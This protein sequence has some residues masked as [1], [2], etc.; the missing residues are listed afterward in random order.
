MELH[1]IAVL[2]DMYKNTLMSL[3]KISDNLSLNDYYDN[4]KQ[5]S[6]FELESC[7]EFLIQEELNI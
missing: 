5:E 7:L 3:K 6:I 4:L 1:S 2:C